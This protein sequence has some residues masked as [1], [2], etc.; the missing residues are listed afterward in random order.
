[1]V[2]GQAVRHGTVNPKSAGSIP[3]TP[4]A[5]VTDAVSSPK[6]EIRVRLP[7]GL[8]TCRLAA[9]APVL[10]TGNRRFESYH[11]YQFTATGRMNCKLKTGK[12]YRTSK[13]MVP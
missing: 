11:V 3:A 4:A 2:Y 8:C 10:Q 1:M 5:Q 13:P 12:S 7:V 9:K 6:A